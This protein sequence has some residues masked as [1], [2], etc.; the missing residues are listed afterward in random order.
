MGYS[1]DVA[2]RHKGFEKKQHRC[3]DRVEDFCK[4]MSGGLPEVRENAIAAFQI[5]VK[6]LRANEGDEPKDA[7]FLLRPE[8]PQYKQHNS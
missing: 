5:I 8:D 4:V 3:N 2:E 7:Y 6:C 1:D